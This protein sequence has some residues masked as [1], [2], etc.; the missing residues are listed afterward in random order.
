MNP[1]NEIFVPSIEE[2]VESEVEELVE[3]IRNVRTEVEAATAKLQE[4]SSALRTKS[5]R[6]SL[7]GAA[8]YTMFSNAH[9][10]LAGALAQ[11]IRRTAPMDRF[12]KAAAAER[13]EA[14]QQAAREQERRAAREKQK[15][16]RAEAS[17]SRLPPTD[18]S[19]DELYGD[20]VRE[21]GSNAQ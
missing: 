15:Q 3:Q 7:E 5:R 20:L 17:E 14:K 2:A 8:G 16:E 11:A 21:E 19:F 18:N 13:E 4:L 10:R 1:Q 9:L 6:G 12:L